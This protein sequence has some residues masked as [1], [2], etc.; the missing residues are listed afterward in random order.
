M[1]NLN[2]DS[3]KNRT[4]DAIV[5]GS[6]ISGGW[7]AK[8]L[9]DKGLK[10]LVLERGRNVEHIKDYPTTN[11]M[12]W[13]FEHRGRIPEDIQKENPVI[14]RCYAFKEDAQHFFVKDTEHPYVQDKPFDWIRGYQVG[15][16]SLLW[17]RQTQRW[18]QYDFEGPARD[19]FAVEWPI[20]YQELAPWYSHV[21]RFSGIS[22]NKDGLDNLPDGDF[23]PPMD[24]NCVEKYFKEKLEGQFKGRNL[25]VA[26]CAHLSEPQSV[27]LE[28][29]RGQCQNRNLCQRGCPFGG[30]FSSNSSTIPWAMKTGNMTLRPHSVVHSVLYDEAQGKA[31]GVK[32][33]DAETKE[34]MDFYAPVIFVN[35]SAL[36]T[37]MILLNSKSNRFP[38][39]LGNDNG[40]L[41]KYVAFHNYRGKISAEYDGYLD[42]T[43]VGRRPTSGY[44]PRF[45]NVYQQET[46]FLRG[47]AS[48]FGASR[49]VDREYEGIGGSLKENLLNPSWGGWRVGSHMMGETIPKESNYVSLDTEKTDEWG[50]PLIKVNV[51]YDDNDEKMTQDFF[52]Q[53]TEMY[54]KAGFI[55]IRTR[56][57]KQAPGLDIH[58][59]GGVRMGKDPKTSLLDKWNRLHACKNV[60]VTD[61][62]CMTSTSTQNPSLTYMAFAAR[63]VDFA[64]RES[65][66]GNV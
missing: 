41:G 24:L 18:S 27:H 45:R 28:Q 15:G 13:E 8:E 61:G 43:T 5:I 2:I 34:E 1:A 52:E 64:V 36:N 22:G 35:A 30:Y 37:N 19:G 65:K 55:N 54:E 17:A 3:E 10:T 11:M 58:E 63:S 26:R 48:G 44:I 38:E 6:G 39:G 59:M 62:A 53:F 12:P 60:F 4:Y 29:G 56:D 23:L 31:S 32:V 9:C 42:S 14:S 51:D 46:D 50:I 47:Y 16:K 66:K 25:I 20:S 40:L 7:A 49:Q 21:E 57:T 33:I